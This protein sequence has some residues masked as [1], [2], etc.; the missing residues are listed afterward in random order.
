MPAGLGIEDLPLET[1]SRNKIFKKLFADYQTAAAQVARSSEFS[2]ALY[3][4]NLRL[5]RDVQALQSQAGQNQPHGYH[6]RAVSSQFPQSHS[7][8]ASLAPSNSISNT[9]NPDYPVAGHSLKRTRPV[10]FP[11]DLPQEVLW[12]LS[13]C[14]GDRDCGTNG[15]NA[16]QPAMRFA[17]RE[18]DG[19]LVHED[20]YAEIKGDVVALC[21]SNLATL[22][23]PKTA[24]RSGKPASRTMTWYKSHDR[25]I[26]EELM[27]E[28]EKRHDVL[29][30]CAGSWKAEHMISSHLNAA[31]S[32]AKRAG[33]PASKG[34][35]KAREHTALSIS[36]AD[37][38]DK[39]ER[40]TDQVNTDY[41]QTPSSGKH[42]R[43]KSQQVIQNGVEGK[44]S[45]SKPKKPRTEPKEGDLAK[46]AHKGDL[47]IIFGL[48]SPSPRRKQ[49]LG[50]N[51]MDSTSNPLPS[52][53]IDISGI[54]VRPSYDNLKES[55][56]CDHPSIGDAVALMDRLKHIADNSAKYP[57][58]EPGST[59]IEYIT[60]LETAD[61][62]STMYSDDETNLGWGHYQFTGGD[63][64]IS[65]VVTSW[66]EIGS[67]SVAHR[68]LAASIRTCRVA[69]YI[70]YQRKVS[71][72]GGY[73]SNMYLGLLIDALWSSVKDLGTENKSPE[74]ESSGIAAE[75]FESLNTT[76][77]DSLKM[78]I[79]KHGISCTKGAKKA[80]M[81]N[82][83]I[84]PKNIPSGNEILDMLPKQRGKGKKSPASPE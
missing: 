72:S 27:A 78:W 11:K 56:S 5:R 34:K 70:C 16:S 67:V 3:E 44:E 18:R 20:K 12:N 4:E 13:D 10:A 21:Q 2:Q 19:T 54:A 6:M 17:L 81:I 66:K 9:T 60:R 23:E 73:I 24:R 31:S 65:T 26:W 30:L 53:T 79:A 82:A 40:Q 37:D 7:R 59:V 57:P 74:P 62:N 8:S 32:T 77:A 42:P 29:Q 71:E 69:R 1:L 43:S 14:Q 47:D 36:D 41:P 38:S 61:P 52:K 58:Q 15:N 84:A 25:E 64:R 68:L 55:L 46:K 33:T 22:K 75:T 49:D 45:P 51:A 63:M 28:L 76:T 80:D 39:E 50:A 83:I 48:K 35:G